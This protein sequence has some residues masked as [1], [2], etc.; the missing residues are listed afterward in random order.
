MTK[1]YLFVTL[2][3]LID[4]KKKDSQKTVDFAFFD[5]ILR[6]DKNTKYCGFFVDN[7]TIYGISWVCSPK[8][9]RTKF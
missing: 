1:L 9:G 5:I 8:N 7:T 6:K 4:K 2:F 3:V